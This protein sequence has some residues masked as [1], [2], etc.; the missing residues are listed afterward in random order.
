[1]KRNKT[2]L[3]LKQYF[4]I[5]EL[6]CKHTF[7]KFGE[8]SWQF[9]DTEFLEM[10]LILRRDVLCAPMTINNWSFGGKF[11]QRGFRCNICPI[12]KKKTLL[13]RI[14]LSA[15]C[16]GAAIDA[17]VKGM[18][19]YQARDLIKKKQAMFPMNIRVEGGVSWLHIDIYD[20][21]KGNKYY[22]FTI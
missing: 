21:G 15:H 16:N 11:T 4:D 13:N 10:L 12:V 5:R 17:D 7:N 6:V 22:S 1:M 3:E 14:Y 20:N 9:F 18:K 2:I 8:K 19:A